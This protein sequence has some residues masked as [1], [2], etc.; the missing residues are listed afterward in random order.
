[1]TKFI[2]ASVITYGIAMI[3]FGGLGYA[4]KGSAVSLIA[5]GVVGVL[6]IASYF[7]WQKNPRA[8][9]IMGVFVAALAAGNAA[10]SLAGGKPFY[11]QGVVLILS[12]LMIVILG[13]GHMMSSKGR[14]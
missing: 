8:G 13:M 7:V 10:K 4:E 5:G 11:P 9:R 3:A 1:M 14:D 12:L 2:N 6:A